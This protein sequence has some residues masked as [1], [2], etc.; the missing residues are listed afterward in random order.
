MD[1]LNRKIMRKMILQ[2]AVIIKEERK[3]ALSNLKIAKYCAIKERKML[4]EGYSRIEINEGIFADLLGLGKDTAF[5][6]RGGFLDTLEQM[7]IEKILSTLFGS[8]D[9]DSFVGAVISNVI[10]NI[11]ITEI[12]KY[13]GSGACDPI[14]ET[15]FKGVSEAIIQQGMDKLFGSQQD[16][17]MISTTMREAFANAVNSSEF[18]VTLKNGI[19]EAICTQDFAGIYK[20]I[21]GGLSNAVGG[22]SDYFK[23]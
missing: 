23:K 10:E 1:K 2:E 22:I 20:T 11:D 14:V 13:F 4:S 18:Q 9:P 21:S 7:V 6:A 16:A 15:L 12:G 17:G 3:I 19:K 8:Y 5:G